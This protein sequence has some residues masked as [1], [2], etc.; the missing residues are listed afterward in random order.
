MI[1]RSSPAQPFMSAYPIPEDQPSECSPYHGSSALLSPPSRLSS[2]SMFGLT[3]SK[4]FKATRTRTLLL[5][6]DRKA[7]TYRFDGDGLE[8][9][10]GWRKVNIIIPMPTTDAD[11]TSPDDVNRK[12][13]GEI[14]TPF[15]RI[16]HKL[17]IRI[18]CRSRAMPG[19]DTIVVLTTPLRCGTAPQARP[20]SVFFNSASKLPSGPSQVPAYCQIF[21]ENGTAREDDEAPPLYA[22]DSPPAYTSSLS[23][24]PAGPQSYVPA[25]LPL[26]I[27][28][29]PSS[30]D[31]IIPASP[32]GA[33][34]DR[35]DPI[36]A[37]V[38]DTVGTQTLSPVPGPRGCRS[39]SSLSTISESDQSS[40]DSQEESSSSG[41]STP[42]P[43]EGSELPHVGYFGFPLQ[44]ENRLVDVTDR[45][46]SEAI[47]P[48][49]LDAARHRAVSR[50]K[51]HRASPSRL[52][53]S[54]NNN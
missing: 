1:S 48:E 19:Q 39:V 35:L 22:P 24:N 53:E 18:V 46:S 52:S 8:L 44:L 45:A 49:Y 10:S 5:G 2:M 32:M 21:H 33:M 17:K 6:E 15:L 12:P 14:D 42:Q 27:P 40:D 16:K 30:L 41:S 38:V 29:I 26:G 20:S 11:S 36:S 28:T 43:G 25:P 9:G 50:V 47:L 54:I 23:A 4:T 7:R 3:S 13:A 37:G 34:D 51:N 31:A